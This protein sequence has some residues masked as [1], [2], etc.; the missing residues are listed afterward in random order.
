MKVNKQVLV[1]AVALSLAPLV[2][3]AQTRAAITSLPSGF[4]LGHG[5]VAVSLSGAYIPNALRELDGDMG[6]ALGLGDAV[7][8]VGFTLSA[9]ITSLEN[10]FA[11]S[12]YFNI[13]AHRQFRFGGG[14]GSVNATV[15]GIGAFGTAAARRVGGSLVASFVTGTAG[16]PYMVTAGIANDLTLARNVQGILGIGVGLNESF[17]VSAGVYGGSNA[18]GVT[19]FPG[20]L[21]NTV[22]QVSLRNLDDPVR[23]GIGVDIGYAFNLFGN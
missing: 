6:L 10:D 18:I 2:A 1:A 11:D 16:R 15:S 5:M 13:G 4:G 20:F 23:R 21:R 17:A 22:V 9:D 8:G 7:N 3:G 14:Y 19:W 12:G